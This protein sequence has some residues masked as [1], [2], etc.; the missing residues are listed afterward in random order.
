MEDV[1]VGLGFSVVDPRFAARRGIEFT[2]AYQEDLQR[3]LHTDASDWSDFHQPG[4]D[5]DAQPVRNVIDVNTE[6][7]DT[8]VGFRM[9]LRMGWTRGRG[10]G[11]NEDGIKEPIRVGIDAGVRLG[12]GKQVEDDHFTNAELVE[13]R[14]MESEIQANEDE[15]R[16]RRREAQV[17]KDAAI[18]EELTEIKKTFYCEVCHKQYE[19]A[20]EFEEHLSS[21][22]HHH[23]KRLVEMRQ[24][25]QARTKDERA[26]K[27]AKA[28]S[29][30]MARLQAQ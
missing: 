27:E 10:L 4:D 9:L 1:A 29:K 23:R 18:Q 28:A 11:S 30:E 8:N 13:R 16:R 20:M 26:R 14:R 22:D 21:Y 19:K 2:N 5:S 17:E 7:P 3:G 6:I 24:M 15:E 12:L 25:E